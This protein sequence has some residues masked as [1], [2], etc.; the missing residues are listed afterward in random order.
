MEEVHVVETWPEDLGELN[1]PMGSRGK[2][3]VGIWGRIL[4]EE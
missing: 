2:A 3:P 4:L 1:P